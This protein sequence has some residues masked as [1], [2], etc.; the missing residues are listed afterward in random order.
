MSVE[1][2]V[3]GDWER[4]RRI[5][6][7]MRRTAEGKILR[8]EM[9]AAIKRT[10]EPYVDI[11][12]SRIRSMRS[13]GKGPRPGLR[14][15]IAARIRVSVKSSAVRIVVGTTARVRGFTTA[16]ARTD[17]GI[18]R[19]PVWGRRTVWVEQIGQKGWFSQTLLPVRSEAKEAIRRI[20]DEMAEKLD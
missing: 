2:E 16:P 9:H 18:W 8:R 17:Q 12:R 6:R 11:L 1:L 14:E 5:H 15:T 13:R 10:L 3:Q 20:L 19:H 4:L 7:A